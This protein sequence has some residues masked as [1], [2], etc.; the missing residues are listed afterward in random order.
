MQLRSELQYE[1][2]EDSLN[3]A[4]LPCTVLSELTLSI[5]VLRSYAVYESYQVGIDQ[6]TVDKIG[7]HR[8][9][10]LEDLPK[11]LGGQEHLNLSFRD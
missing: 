1:L 10:D 9:R 4:V 5:I 3:R 7:S 8:S 11:E 2:P 6:L